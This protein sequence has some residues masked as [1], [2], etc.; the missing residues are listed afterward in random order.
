VRDQFWT[1][2]PYVSSAFNPWRIA[3]G[4]ITFK[5]KFTNL[6]LSGHVKTNQG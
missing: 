4:Y 1:F 5:S 6:L 3:P 2:S